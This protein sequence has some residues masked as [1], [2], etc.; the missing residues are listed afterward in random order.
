MF[1]DELLT[2]Q[3]HS[4]IDIKMS[5]C[6]ISVQVEL[7]EKQNQVDTLYNDLIPR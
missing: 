5:T 2:T 6:S 1:T 3:V 7:K 4:P